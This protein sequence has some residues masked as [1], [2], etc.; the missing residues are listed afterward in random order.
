MIG[1]RSCRSVRAT[2]HAAGP[3][4]ARRRGTDR[5]APGPT[6]G[7]TISA[8]GRSQADQRASSQ[9]RE[10]EPD[11]GR[12]GAL[13]QAADRDV[14]DPGRGD[15]ARWCRAG[16]RPRPR[17]APGRRPARP[18][19]AAVAGPM[20]SSSRWVA[21]AASAGSIWSSRSTSQMIS[22][23]PGGLARGAP[24]R[25]H[26]RRPATWL[27][28]II[29]ASH[30]PMRWFCAPPVRVAYFSRWRRPGM[31]LRVSSRTRVGPAHRVDIGAGHRGDARQVLDG[32]ERAALG[33]EHA[34]GHCR[35][36]ASGRCPAGDLRAFLDEQLDLHRRVERA[37]EGGGDR[38]PGTRRSRRGCPSRRRTA[39]R[40]GSRSR[41]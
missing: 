39:P 34:R 30:R 5:L 10:I 32:V 3:M 9:R 8:I 14:V 37:E 13:G 36:G 28:L 19:R 21:P 29:A 40:R 35:P 27:S 17:S 6:P 31:V 4:L 41:W 25:R 12:R 7:S 38:Q 24:P 1:G 15:R 2:A 20:L 22:R 11:V 18:P 16:P 26:R 33:G 23:D